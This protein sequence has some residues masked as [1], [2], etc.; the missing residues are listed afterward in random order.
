MRIEGDFRPSDETEHFYLTHTGATAGVPRHIK[1]SQAIDLNVKVEQ[2]Y[3]INLQ[4]NL[5]AW[6][7]NPN[8]YNFEGF[9]DGMMS[10]HRQLQLV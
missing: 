9:D 7:D 3:Q 1:Y 5:N 2:D 4:M 8:T 10:N 6:Y